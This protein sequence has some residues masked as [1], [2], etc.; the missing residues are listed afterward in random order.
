MG[1]MLV[2]MP[3]HLLRNGGKRK[4]F[5]GW[6]L[7]GAASTTLPMRSAHGFHGSVCSKPADTRSAPSQ[8]AMKRSRSSAS[9]ELLAFAVPFFARMGDWVRAEAELENLRNAGLPHAFG[10]ASARF[11]LMRGDLE[12]AARSAAARIAQLPSSPIDARYSMLDIICAQNG[13]GRRSHCTAMDAREQ[14]PRGF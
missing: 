12:S 8:P 4:A 10:E 9:A 2:P 11:H 6:N 1:T 3:M 13:R 5:S 14:K 7:A